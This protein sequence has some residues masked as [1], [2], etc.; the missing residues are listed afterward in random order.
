[1]RCVVGPCRLPTA[2]RTD[3]RCQNEKN[4][5]FLY[6][7][8]RSKYQAPSPTTF[9]FGVEMVITNQLIPSDDG[10]H[11]TD[12]FNFATA[13]ASCHAHAKRTSQTPATTQPR[14]S[15]SLASR[16]TGDGK[17]QKTATAR[18][19]PCCPCSILLTC[20]ERNCPCAKARRA[21]QNCDTSRGRC[22]NTVD[23]HNA[24]IR[25]ANHDNLPRSTSARFRARM[26][27]LP[28]SLIPL[29]VEPA[30]RMEDD[31]ELATTASAATQR[32][33]R[34]VNPLCP[35][36]PVRETKWPC[37][38]MEVT[39]APP[40][41]CLLETVRSCCSVRTAA[42]PTPSHVPRRDTSLTHQY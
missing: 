40:P 31:N 17:R 14:W 7:G 29:I 32:H 6:P 30:E 22:S 21:C 8:I 23:A 19:D 38:P 35:E 37:R 33:I 27:L 9:I 28:R 13:A 34:C 4:S 25:E 2:L 36:L 20:S 5:D 39:P 12:A 16:P 11:L 15:S 18:K 42:P 1:M 3:V 24:V 10:Q 26:G 41:N